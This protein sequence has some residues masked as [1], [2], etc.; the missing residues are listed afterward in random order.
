MVD[1]KLINKLGS[2]RNT[3]YGVNNDW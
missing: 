1:K 2:G 3:Y